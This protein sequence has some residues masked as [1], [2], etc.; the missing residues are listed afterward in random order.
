MRRFTKKFDS[1]FNYSE[2]LT[3]Y[4]LYDAAIKSFKIIETKRIKMNKIQREGFYFYYA[5]SLQ[6]LNMKIDANY[7]WKKLLTSKNFF[8]KS[9]AAYFLGKNLLEEGKK[10]EAIN[11]FKMISQK[12]SESKYATYCWNLLKTIK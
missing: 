1:M 12:P 11:L 8:K 9:A 5:W 2:L 6:Q 3:Y 10:K 4:K 7:R